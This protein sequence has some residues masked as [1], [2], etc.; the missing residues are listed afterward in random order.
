MYPYLISSHNRLKSA[1]F[2]LSNC[3]PFVCSCSWF[4]TLSNFQQLVIC[5]YPYWGF[6]NKYLTSRGAQ[7]NFP[8]FFAS[9]VGGLSLVR[10]D[11][12]S[13]VCAC[14]RACV[15]MCVCICVCVCV[16]ACV[17]VCVTGPT[18]STRWPFA[19]IQLMTTY[20]RRKLWIRV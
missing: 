1:D 3:S 18:V 4:R 11:L 13:C 20:F 12:F 14:V 16:R 8:V 7:T 2:V 6:S 17:R 5:F 19:E 10:N 15:C 9:S